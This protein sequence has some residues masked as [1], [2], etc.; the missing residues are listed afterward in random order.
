LPDCPLTSASVRTVSQCRGAAD[1]VRQGAGDGGSGRR[2]NHARNNR[3]DDP[4]LIAESAV[5]QQRQPRAGRRSSNRTVI[6]R[7]ALSMSPAARRSGHFSNREVDSPGRP[8]DSPARAIGTEA[9]SICLAEIPSMRS[10]ALPNRRH[11]LA[12]AGL[13]GGVSVLFALPLVRPEA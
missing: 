5:A 9:V 7:R 2:N 4:G 6:A 11:R 13:P 12:R 10:A 8:A 3:A 1:G